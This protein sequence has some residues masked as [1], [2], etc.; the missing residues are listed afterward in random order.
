[1]PSAD[2][3]GIYA[4]PTDLNE[5]SVMGQSPLGTLMNLRVSDFLEAAGL[6]ADTDG[7]LA[8]LSAVLPSGAGYLKKVSGSPNVYSWDVGGGGSGPTTE[9][10]QDIVGAMVVAGTGITVTY[11]DG[12]NTLTVAQSG[13]PV[14]ADDSIALVK[15]VEATGPARLIGAESAGPW[16]EL[17]LGGGLM[18]SGGVLNTTG[19]SGTVTSVGLGF[20]GLAATIFA[21]GA[22]AGP[23]TSNGTLNI[24]FATGLTPY[25]VL[26]TNASGD[27]TLVTIDT[28]Y[29]ATVYAS[30]GDIYDLK[31][32]EV[33]VATTAN[34]TLAT[35]Y[36]NGDTV[37]G[38]TLAT[39]DLILLKNQSSA[40]ENGPYTVNASGAP[41][42]LN[43]TDTG[44]RILG[45]IFY[46]REGTANGGKIFRNTN[47]TAITVGA[48]NVT[49]TEFGG[50]TVLPGVATV[51][52]AQQNFNNGSLSDGGTISWDVSTK[53]STD[54]TLGGNRTLANPTNMVNHGTYILRVVQD[55]TGS[56][57]LAYGSAYKWPGGVAPTLST[58]AGDVDI[59][60]FVSDGTN[61]YGS[62]L[63][64]FS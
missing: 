7:I 37:D 19:S 59:L 5:A 53:Q 57:T 47:T 27:F 3:P 13:S 41:T 33:R 50:G 56:R 9:E 10:I 14:L 15:L 38:V 24:E 61:M 35:A 42:R 31:W 1:M 43:T 64:D 18:I 36:E 4:D 39:G 23:I 58:G 21:V 16:T 28:N 17:T 54:V 2:D 26:G 32:K 48:T 6:E 22:T 45:S 51:F 49:Y 55:G 12:A 8:F 44:A 60:T 52:T 29:F 11:N 30:L 62:C 34:G 40:T 25:R 63:K 46:V 20:T